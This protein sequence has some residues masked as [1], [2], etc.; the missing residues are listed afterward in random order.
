M[1][2]LRRAYRRPP[3]ANLPVFEGAGVS[4]WASPVEAKL[5]EGEE[6][7]LGRRRQFGRTGGRVSLRRGSSGCISSS[8]ARASKSSM[9]RYLIERID[10]LANVEL[11]TETEMV[12]LEGDGT[13]GLTGAVFRDRSNRRDACLPTAA[14]VPVHRRRAECRLA[15]WLRRPRR[16]GLRVDR[17]R[18]ARQAGAAGAAA[19]NQPAGRV[20]DR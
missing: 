12:G 15:R 2:A 6:S 5:C 4:Y 8:A 3:I 14:S 1:I 9:S 13:T 18:H 19:R 7:G 16:Q 20:R 10:A 11:H 17:Q